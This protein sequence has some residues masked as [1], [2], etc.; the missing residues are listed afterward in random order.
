MKKNILI[1]VI[2]ALVAFGMTSCEKT[3]TK[4]ELLTEKS[5]SLTKATST[6]A[7]ELEAGVNITDLFDGFIRDY[8]LDDLLRFDVNGGV[9]L[10]PGKI[11]DEGQAAGEELLGKWSFDENTDKLDFYLPYY[12]EAV[13]GTVTVLNETTLTVGVKISED[14]DIIAKATRNYDFILSYTKK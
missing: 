8:E 12:E 13:V 2:C 7:Y 3:K 5:W 14:D 11:R 9:F 6:P 1:G 4:T 10:N